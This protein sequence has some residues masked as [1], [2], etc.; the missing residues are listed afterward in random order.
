MATTTKLLM[1]I[2]NILNSKI[3]DNEKIKEIRKIVH[4]EMRLL[5]LNETPAT[6]EI[7]KNKTKR[8]N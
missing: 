6:D 2:V 7:A 4:V 1:K 3:S 8:G 5:F